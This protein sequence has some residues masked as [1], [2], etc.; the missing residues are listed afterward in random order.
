MSLP[1]QEVVAAKLAIRDAAIQNHCRSKLVGY[2]DITNIDDVTNLTQRLASGQLSAEHVVQAYI[3]QWV[4]NYF[5]VTKANVGQEPVK[6]NR[7]SMSR[8]VTSSKY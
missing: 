6:H 1:W 7:R 5:I 2:S 3:F 4:S 8:L